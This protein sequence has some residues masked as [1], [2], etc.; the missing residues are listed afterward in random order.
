M[1]WLLG[2]D[3]VVP[4]LNWQVNFARALG[5]AWQEYQGL[6]LPGGMAHLADLTRMMILWV[7]DFIVPTEYVR[8]IWHYGMLILG[9]I[10]VW[11]LGRRLWKWNGWAALAAGVFYLFN[12]ATVQYFYVPYEAFSSFYGFLPWLLAVFLSYLESGKTRELFWVMFVGL[13]ATSA[14][15]VQTLFVVYG[16]ILVILSLGYWRQWKRVLMAFLTILVMNAFWLLPVAY[17]VLQGGSLV[18]QAKINSI[19]SPETALYNQGFGSWRDVL[20]LRGYW[21]EWVEWNGGSE[22]GRMMQSYWEWSWQMWVTA[23]GLGVFGMSIVGMVWS[24]VKK[25]LR[26]GW[27]GGVILAY[28]ML[29]S[30]NIPFGGIYGWLVEK[31]PLFGEMFR[32]VFTKWSV[33]MAL[34]ISV[35]L[36]GLVARIRRKWVGAI[37]AMLL[38]GVSVIGVWPVFREGLVFSKMKVELPGEY[39]KLFEFMKGQEWG[40]VVYLPAQDMWSWKYTDWGYRGSGFLWYGIEQPILDRAFDVWSPYNETFYN[41]F[42]TALYGCINNSQIINSQILKLGCR[43]LVAKVL[44]KYDVRYVLLDERVIAPGQDKKIL[45]I[46]ETKKLASELGW[47]QK[48]NEGFLTVWETPY[49]KAD[50]FVSAP[51]QY[52]IVSGDTTKTRNDVIYDDVGSYVGGELGARYPFAGLLREEIKNV[53][54]DQ[55]GVKIKSSEIDMGNELIIPGWEVGEIVR[56]DFATSS[57]TTLGAQGEPLPA[58]FV[59]GE[60]GPRFLGEEKPKEGESYFYARVSEREEWEEYRAEQKYETRNLPAGK[61]GEKLE[62]EVKGKP[63]VYD[64]GRQGQGSIGNCDV[65][66]RGRAE[67][68]GSIY[69]ADERGAVCDYVVM[70][71]LFTRVPH[72]MRVVGE[73]KGGRSLK[74]FLYNTGS[75]RND[76]EYLMYKDKFDQTFSLLPWDWDGHY[77]LNIET[78]SFGQ[79]AENRVDKVEVRYAP[80]EKIAKAK[81]KSRDQD[82]V[83]KENKL[84]ITHVK[85]TGTWLY[86][87]GLRGEG[88]IRLSQGYDEGWV[89]VEIRNENFEIRKLEHVKADGWA[90]EW[91]IG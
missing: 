15:Y 63:F 60:P 33:V 35:G 91:I 51:T 87:L 39:T 27:I 38:V 12:L 34:L 90:N 74:F 43:E 37:V 67:K 1:T 7:I 44:Q 16:M 83:S 64:F 70:D 71:E 49:G 5:G 82:V 36:G 81:V 84:E 17:G 53:D 21:L 4:E 10:G 40:R 25:K 76:I 78:R 61:A 47:E 66:K 30:N 31:V 46:E 62:I 23:L 86:G 48:F 45:I 19:G 32:S 41:E 79:Y 13:A 2:W 77:S 72:L 26:W 8:W 50:K 14:F 22:G 11:Y 52:T 28:I 59:N 75:E 20:S 69:I 80:I 73:N 56:V 3:S 57:A 6:G 42:S 85:K 9:P 88:L 65:L 68:Q 29:G 89:G 54:W 58:Y 24:T 55:D 18:G